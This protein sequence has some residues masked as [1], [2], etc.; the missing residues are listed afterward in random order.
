M[1]GKSK[2]FPG[3]FRGFRCVIR[4]VSPGCPVGPTATTFR[5]PFSDRVLFS[6][7]PRIFTTRATRPRDTSVRVCSLLPAQGFHHV[8][9]GC[10]VTFLHGP[11]RLCLF[12][13]L[14]FDGLLSHDIRS[15]RIV[16]SVVCSGIA[17]R[18]DSTC[19]LSERKVADSSK[20]QSTQT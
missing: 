13:R 4:T 3:R 10:A 2:V 16:L 9:R 11:N 20:L 18:K 19:Q 8:V 5:F 7:T 6:F 12:A 1:P 14:C 17:N 15:F